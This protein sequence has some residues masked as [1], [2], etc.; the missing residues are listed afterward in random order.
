[1]LRKASETPAQH[2][3]TASQP[4]DEK[5]LLDRCRA[6]DRN[7]FDELIRVHEK[8][9][10]NF[11]YRLS[12]NYDDANDITSETFL[13]VYN[14]IAN[15]R[16]DSSFITWLFRIANNVYLD[17][18]KKQRAHPSQSLEEIIELEDSSVNRQ[19]M[20]PSPSLQHIIEAK[21]KTD[22]LQKA[23][24]TLPDYDGAS[25]PYGKSFL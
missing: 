19:I 18:R 1:V 15:F 10:F 20:D 7:A 17:G 12:G 23:I 22:I 4:G 6:G 25:L 9:V 16:G 8:K 3:I 5:N 11:A 24:D 21:E 2:N 14:A 13:R